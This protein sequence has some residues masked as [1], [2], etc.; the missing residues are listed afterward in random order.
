MNALR[1]FFGKQSDLV[2]VLGV[3][4]ILMVLVTPIPPELLDFLLI[5]NLSF[6]LLILGG[7]ASQVPPVGCEHSACA[8]DHP[9]SAAR[10]ARPSSSDRGKSN[11]VANRG[12]RLRPR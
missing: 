11:H 5:L 2:L 1:E 9:V 10:R 12:K 4:C 8:R 3:V 6:A 7:S